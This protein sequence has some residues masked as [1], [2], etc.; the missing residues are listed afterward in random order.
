[1]H[2]DKTQIYIFSSTGRNMNHFLQS[3]VH[4]GL[5]T[6]TP[7]HVYK[8]LGIT[9]DSKVTWRLHIKR[10]TDLAR[11][12]IWPSQQQR[13]LLQCDSNSYYCYIFYIFLCISVITLNSLLHHI[14]S[15]DAFIIH[16]ILYTCMKSDSDHYF[17]AS[18]CT[19]KNT[20]QSKHDYK[21]LNE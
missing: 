12:W 6:V 7:K 10:T 20:I 3:P 17:I 5:S 15:H 9:L 2:A 8:Y 13:P 14:W 16:F 4:V 19:F 1:M 11:K 18:S 21:L